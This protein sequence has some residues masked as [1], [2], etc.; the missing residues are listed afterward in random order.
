M[1]ITTTTNSS[2]HKRTMKEKNAVTKKRSE[3]IYKFSSSSR[4][5]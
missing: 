4:N 1:E 2:K 3:I 5:Y